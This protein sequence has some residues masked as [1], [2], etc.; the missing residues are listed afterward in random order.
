M[1]FQVDCTLPGDRDGDG[2]EDQ[3]KVGEVYDDAPPELLA[4][5]QT[6]RTTWTKEPYS[7][8]WGTFMSLFRPILG[9]DGKTTSVVGVD[10]ELARHN[11]RML[12]IHAAADR[13]LKFALLA[14]LGVG[15]GFTWLR[16]ATVRA[17]SA[18]IAPGVRIFVPSRSATLVIGLV[19]IST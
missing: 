18:W 16:R 6:G 3:A 5:W 8:E 11:L 12:S 9:A 14:G 10:M 19:H 2:R 17:Q 13:G 1:L 7:D 4:A 15:L